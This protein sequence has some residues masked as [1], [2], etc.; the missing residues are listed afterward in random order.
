MARIMEIKDLYNSYLTI[1][2]LTLDEIQTIC[3][4]PMHIEDDFRTICKI[5]KRN[6]KAADLLF[7]Q[8][9]KKEE[10]DTQSFRTILNRSKPQDL[11]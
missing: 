10:E 6:N 8:F 4:D 1:M 7:Q 9:Y 3:E 11:N 5:V 2:A